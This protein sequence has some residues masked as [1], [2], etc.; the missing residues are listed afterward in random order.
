MR[1]R[2]GTWL[3]GT[4]IVRCRVTVDDGLGEAA[5]G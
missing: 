5:R 1:T 4:V 2:M 3:G